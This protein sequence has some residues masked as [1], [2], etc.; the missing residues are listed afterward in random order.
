MNDASLPILVLF[1]V[2]L[3]PLMA[4]IVLITAP[5]DAWRA[6]ISDCFSR[7]SEVERTRAAAMRSTPARTSFILTRALLRLSLGNALG[8]DPGT[9]VFEY[10][11][12]GKPALK[13]C[14]LSFNVSHTPGMSLIAFGE[15]PFLGVDVE[16]L[17]TRKDLRRLARAVLNDEE[18]RAWDQL[19]E[20]HQPRAFLRSWTL[21]EAF[22]KATGLGLQGGLKSVSMDKHSGRLMAIPA[23][24]GDPEE[25]QVERW[26][27]GLYQGAVVYRGPSQLL[28]EIA[29]TPQNQHQW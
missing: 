24:D 6:D 16:R 21:K 5:H 11:I 22:L 15:V 29:L 1:L 28:R 8:C 13:E 10:G 18:F 20:A 17:K 27:Q 26:E 4:E 25:W 9:F 7:L 14:P 2:N 3:N 19:D 23:R 12:H